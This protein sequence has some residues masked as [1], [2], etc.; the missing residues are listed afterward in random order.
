MELRYPITAFIELTESCNLNCLHCYNNSSSKRIKSWDINSLKEFVKE[1]ARNDVSTLTLSGGEPLLYKD[2]WDLLAF[3]SEETN[4]KL[5]INTNGILLDEICIKKLLQY[6]VRDMQISLDGMKTNHDYIRGYGSFHRTINSIK[7]AI[8]N[9]IGVKIGYTINSVN[10]N[11]LEEITAY[12]KSLGVKS[13]AV[14]RFVPTSIRDINKELDLSAVELMKISKKIIE[15]EE[16]YSTSEFQIYYDSLAFFSFIYK[17]ELVHRSRCLAGV[18]QINLTANKEVILCA[19]NKIHV[20]FVMDNNISKYWDEVKVV[21]RNLDRE[22][23]YES[24]KNCNFEEICRGG[25]PGI[26]NAYFKTNCKERDPG[27]FKYL[28]EK[29][30]C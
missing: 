11:D 16:K 17:P 6:G 9:N 14:Y 7:K 20:D 8:Y 24:C 28:Y 5:T 19:H 22:E 13:I 29:E 1:L 15:V 27:C 4:L 26:I 25:C 12:S 30:L 10:K 3:I 18:G 23:S 21:K 2:I